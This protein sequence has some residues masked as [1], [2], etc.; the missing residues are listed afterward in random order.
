MVSQ[1][2]EIG[3]SPCPND[4][5]IFGAWIQGRLPSRFDLRASFVFSDV[6]DLNRAAERER[7][8]VVKVSAVQGIRL[9]DKYHILPAGAA[10]GSAEGPK[11]MIRK[12]G[13]GNPETIAVPGLN[14]TAVHLLRA[15][16]Q[17]PFQTVPVRYDK[18]V[19][20]V[21]QGRVEAGLLIHE[22]ALNP[23]QYGLEKILDLG[24]WWKEKYKDTPLPLG[25][26]LA[27]RSLGPKI[28]DR[29]C[30]HIR[31]S[32][33]RSM[34]DSKPIMPFV[35]SMAQELNEGIIRDHIAAYVS[36]LSLDMGDSGRQ[37][38]EVLRQLLWEAKKT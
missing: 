29:I 20:Q 11:L 5:F 9:E 24:K 31:E 30:S 4:I 23:E 34:E 15:A 14:T 33:C 35:K 28:A 6:E 16:A 22:T 38:L 17:W 13:G 27:S 36:E 12:G 21:A 7:F 32:L 3:I 18:I 1:T 25:V 26:I 37:G 2:I 10:F 8:P 19:E